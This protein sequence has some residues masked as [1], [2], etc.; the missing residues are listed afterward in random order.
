M[1]R[2]ISFDVGIKNLAYCVLDI[3]ENDTVK[4]VE[5]TDWKVLDLLQ[6]IQRET[7]QRTSTAVQHN[8]PPT[9]TQILTSKK[10]FEMCGKVAKYK[11]PD[12]GTKY[13][14]ERHAKAAAGPPPRGLW[15]PK[16][17][18]SEASLKKL[19]VQ[20]LQ[21][22]IEELQIPKSSEKKWLKA[23]M[24]Q[25]LESYYRKHTWQIIRDESSCTATTPTPTPTT[26]AKTDLIFLGRQIHEHFSQS[27]APRE[28]THVLIEN[29]I[30]PIANRMKTIQGMLTQEFIVQ[31]CPHIEY[32]SSA[33][34]LKSFR[35][36][37]KKTG[38][39]AV[40]SK[41]AYT[42]HKKDAVQYCREKIE[43][44]LR[45]EQALKWLTFFEKNRTK[46]DDLADSFL[47]GIW[48]VE[49]KLLKDATNIKI[50]NMHST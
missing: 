9:C 16:K 28:I 22:R 17:E 5:I 49:E 11:D 6:P 15:I 25:A 18:Y 34:K 38:D 45:P 2:I 46:K 39:D 30:S 10:H 21:T 24:I 14:C 26:A 41:S 33:N 29:Q 12:G 27:N 31:G 3:V 20:S 37:T 4:T 8:S 13:M 7:V 43:S 32:V 40:K 36:K 35:G 44:I 19:S 42:E 48:F 1:P 23:D 50:N 47:Q